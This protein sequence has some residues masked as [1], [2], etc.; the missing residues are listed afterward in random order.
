[1]VYDAF[2][3]FR[4]EKGKYKFTL[5]KEQ[6]EKCDFLFETQAEQENRRLIYV[7]LTRAIYGCFIFQN[8]KNSSSLTPFIKNI[9]ENSGL[10]EKVVYQMKDL[11]Y[12]PHSNLIAYTYPENVNLNFS[13]KNR[14]KMSFSFLSGQHGSSPKN[15]IKKYDENSY[16][17]W[18]FHQ[19]E[20]GANVGNLL[21]SIFEYLD[22]NDLE[23]REVVIE[24]SLKRYLPKKKGE[25]QKHLEELVS[26][27]L[28]TSIKIEEA[29]IRLC[30][31]K[32]AQKC[33][34]ME[35]DINLPE[36]SIR[37]LHKLTNPEINRSVNTI[38]ADNYSGVLNGL[39]DLFFES[40]G[41]YYILDW[42][43]NYLGD[44]LEDY[45]P[46]RLNDA[47]NE[48]NYHLQYFIYML[49]PCFINNK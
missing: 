29:E 19:L 22:F 33:P 40:N 6:D 11:D 3:S 41:K 42:K 7:A 46:D 45:T 5:N 8:T 4:D 49:F 28:N 38:Y 30:Q 15:K 47:M 1:M 35:F 37:D 13:D 18:I 39:M 48:N 14:R 21:H 34:E 24:K 27:I 2:K 44:D 23:N 43:S 31:V 32:Q 26:V 25:Y 20:K 16:D 9:P 10:I 17:Y 36:F 12:I